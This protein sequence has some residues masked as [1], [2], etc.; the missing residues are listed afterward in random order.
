[1]TLTP[2]IEAACLRLDLEAG[3]A[4]LKFRGDEAFFQG[5]FPGNPVLPAMT[6]IAAAR[7]VAEQMTGRSLEVTEVGRAKF[8]RP[9]GPG[10]ELLLKVE[11]DDPEPKVLR[12]KAT[13]RTQEHEVAAFTLRCR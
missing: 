3:T 4:V 9:V 6:Q 12:V 1:M 2:D 13:L 5:H 10:V 7:H 11:L 8:T